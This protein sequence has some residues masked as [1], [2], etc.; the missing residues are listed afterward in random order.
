MLLKGRVMFYME[1]ITGI[2]AYSGGCKSHG[3]QFVDGGF[4]RENSD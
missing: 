1:K 4:P 2:P 3:H